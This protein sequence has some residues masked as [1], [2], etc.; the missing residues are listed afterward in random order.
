MLRK[1]HADIMFLQNLLAKGV[2]SLMIE[3]NYHPWLM[4]IDSYELE[5]EQDSRLLEMVERK[6]LRLQQLKDKLYSDKIQ[7][8]IDCDQLSLAIG[9]ARDEMEV[10]SFY[11]HIQYFAL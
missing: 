4:C 7:C 1:I 2:K 8:Q 3:Y 5:S 9:K 10:N 11:L 6:T